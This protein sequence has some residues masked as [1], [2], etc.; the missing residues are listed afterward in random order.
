MALPIALQIYSV[1][2]ELDKDFFGTLK[3][4]KEM[5][6]DG[7]ELSGLN[8]ADP[9][10]VKKMLDE[11]DL[12]VNSSHAPV[13]ELMEDGAMER[14]QQAGCSYVVIPWMSYGEN[15]VDLQKNLDVIRTLAEKAKAQGLTLLYH[16]HNF[17]FE[18]VDGRTILDTIY[19]EIPAD[20]LQTQI[21]TCWVKFAGTD[22]AAYVRKYAG[23]APLVHL[24][25]F[26]KEEA[27][28]AV[29]YD[30]IG[31]ENAP[32]KKSSFE[33]RPVG[34]GM[35]DIPAILEASKAAGAD[36]VIVEQ[37]E[38]VGRG[39]LEAA[40]MSIDYLHSLEW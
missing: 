40:K 39:T 8:G 3:K 27:D 26:W 22:P 12:Q 18:K 28:D 1:R 16:N 10:K 31:Q 32:K 33:F 25:D 24:K 21:D 37:D 9:V 19:E 20:L 7:V 13:A 15:N 23:R 17:E 6:Y 14:Y 35:Q 30:L 36:W 11:L 4:V 2:D 34:Y 38:S 5:G 29:P